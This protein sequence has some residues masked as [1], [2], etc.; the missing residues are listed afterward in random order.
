[1]SKNGSIVITSGPLW[2]TS[3]AHNQSTPLF[4]HRKAHPELYNH[5][6]LKRVWGV[7]NSIYGEER[8]KDDRSKQ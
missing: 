8:S 4:K 6:G 3:E 2:N 7:W 5:P 1:M